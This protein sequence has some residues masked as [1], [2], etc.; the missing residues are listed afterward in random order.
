MLQRS[1]IIKKHFKRS[2][3]FLFVT[4]TSLI[5]AFF[6]GALIV[7][8]DNQDT[9]RPGINKANEKNNVK[10]GWS[11]KHSNT[12]FNWEEIQGGSSGSGGGGEGGTGGGTSNPG[13]GEGGTSDGTSNPG[14]GEGGTG[15]G[16]LST[17][18]WDFINGKYTPVNGIYPGFPYGPANGDYNGMPFP[19]GAGA[20][21][22]FSPYSPG[23]NG[24]NNLSNLNK[25][26][27]SDGSK[28]QLLERDT[29][30]DE[31]ED[32][33]SI[34]D[35]QLGVISA[36]EDVLKDA[37]ESNAISFS[38]ALIKAPLSIA[39]TVF[40]NDAL[41]VANDAI[42]F[43]IDG[44]TGSVGWISKFKE[45][46]SFTNGAS[47]FSKMGTM[48]KEGFKHLG[49]LGK[50]F[51][52]RIGDS[53]NS[54]KSAKGFLGK[55]KNIASGTGN[56]FGKV[57]DFGGTQWNK[58]GLFGKIATPVA[59]V[60]S[61]F[62]GINAYKDFKN[63]DYKGVAESATSAAGGLL[64]A[65]AP[66]TGPAAPIVGG[67]GLGLSAISLGIKHWN[68]ISAAGRA[69]GRGVANAGRAVGRGVAN[70]GRAV[71]RGVS[72]AYN[73]TTKAVGNAA[74]AVGNAARGLAKGIGS[75]FG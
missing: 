46:H 15:N 29:I 1:D 19:A 74:N 2:F 51:S 73:A 35:T 32:G 41:D 60:G 50:N 36:F 34:L 16:T 66:F 11:N 65:V 47:M 13:G 30:W 17:P 54:F 61:V 12:E 23:Y 53:W 63:G 58:M 59:A 31:I 71:G 72:N 26:A 70:A 9:P 44:V 20:L 39:N 69:I 62:D 21:G 7:A 67:I 49:S 5:L 28:A 57:K 42:G 43:T 55:T 37:T 6:P 48:G 25:F 38:S 75:L 3:K 56:F 45:T 10:P 18:G 24:I 52:Q 68:K 64:T 22:I 14:S 4:L 33:A 8:A 27:S 40:D